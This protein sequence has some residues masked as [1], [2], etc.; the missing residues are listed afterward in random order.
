MATGSLSLLEAAKYG[1]TTLGRGVVSTLIQESPILEMLPFTSI[2]GNALKV[3]VEDTL[4]T[5]AFRDVNETY[6]RTHGTDTERFF[7]CAILGGEVFI[8]NYIVRVQ[9]DQISAK[10]R[11]YSKFAKAMSRTFDASFFDGTGTSKDFK[12]INSLIT[13]G[14][15]QTVTGAG[16]NGDAL[17]LD[18]LD[19]TFDSLRSQ[20]SPDAL[21]MNRLNRRNINK[22]ARSTYSGVSLIDVGTD[23]F[24]RQV[25]LYNGTPI[26]IIGDDIGGT[27]ILSHTEVKGSS[28]A[29]SSIY[30]IA[31]GTDENVYGILGLGGSFD[32]VDFGE[33]E[34]APG[35]LGRVEVYPGV[36]VS[37]S[38]SVCRLSGMLTV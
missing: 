27:P 32:V 7:G 10:A 18:L 9:A 29:T 35:H 11:Q 33:T 4:P 23:V 14:L 21:L 17:T 28:S 15:G 2:T 22:L 37:N 16:A 5:P 19:E 13:E 8:D 1:S 12:G 24:G 30:A 34:A 6:S 25:N 26:R 20:S 38:F 3:T 31:F 36:V